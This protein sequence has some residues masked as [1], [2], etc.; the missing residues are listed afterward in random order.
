MCA[1]PSW[2][3]SMVV[4][5]VPAAG[6]RQRLQRPT[7]TG[8][9]G[10]VP[11]RGNSHGATSGTWKLAGWVLPSELHMMCCHPLQICSHRLEGIRLFPCVKPMQ[12]SSTS[13]LAWG[14]SLL[15]GDTH[16]EQTRSFR[17]VV[18]KTEC[19]NAQLLKFAWGTSKTR[20][21]NIYSWPI[22]S[23]IGVI[24]LGPGELRD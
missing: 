9:G 24:I 21:C 3:S 13:C 2:R 4:E 18:N 19:I 5:K 12:R 20:L 22:T 7:S 16:G 11:R 6:S 8:W 14:P 15:R 23:K 1:P 17:C 10:R